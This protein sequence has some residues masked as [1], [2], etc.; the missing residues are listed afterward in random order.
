MGNHELE[1][2]SELRSGDMKDDRNAPSSH[3]D[4]QQALGQELRSGDMK[5]DRKAPEGSASFQSEDER[6]RGG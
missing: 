3:E 2:Q 6:L 5:D 4:S 1:S